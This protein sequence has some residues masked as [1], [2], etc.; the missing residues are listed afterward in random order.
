MH[1]PT[2]QTRIQQSFLS[3][4]PPWFLKSRF[5]KPYH[6]FPI[7]SQ[8]STMHHP[9]QITSLRITYYLPSIC[10]AIYTTFILINLVSKIY[11]SWKQ[12]YEPESGN[13]GEKLSK[14]KKKTNQTN[15]SE[16]HVLFCAKEIHPQS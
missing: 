16:K 5:K 10:D 4:I 9:L 12:V 7:I 11:I 2:S 8:H 15:L 3:L 14:K 1:C 6:N 13:D